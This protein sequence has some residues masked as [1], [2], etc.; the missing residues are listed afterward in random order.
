MTRN[1]IDTQSISDT[2]LVKARKKGADHAVVIIHQQN[3]STLRFA[4]NRATQSMNS[5]K[6]SLTLTV[7]IGTREAS[8]ETDCTSQTCIEA[9]V[10]K[11]VD[12]ARNAPENPEFVEPIPAQT[13][14]ETQTWFESTGSVTS[15]QQGESI[16]LMCDYARSRDVNLFGNLNVHRGE[17]S[18]AN[19]SGLYARQAYSDVRLFTTAR[20]K[21]GGGS[22]CAASGEG[23]WNLLDPLKIAEEAVQTAIRS[24]YPKKVNPGEYVV[25][26]APDA[27]L[28]YLMYILF[29]LDSREAE[30]GQSFFSNRETGGVRTGELIFGKDV[31]L[32]SLFDHS[33]LPTLPFGMTFGSGGSQAGMHFCFGLPM[34]NHIWVEN[35]YLMRLRNSPYWAQKNNRKMVACPFNIVLEGTDTHHEELITGIK[36][37]IYISSFWYTSPTDMTKLEVTGLTRD[38]TFL[39]ENGRIT[40]SLVNFRFND[41]PVRSLNKLLAISRQERVEGEFINGLMPHV[42]IDGFNLTSISEAT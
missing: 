27:L 30:L 41:S 21:S 6:V 34:Q 5:E 35:G 15:A 38:G 23:D 1:K 31:T 24:R 20:S 36:R 40:D 26:L 12:F 17:L 4:L 37:G 8:V 42:L 18:A 13:Y 33:R 16:R 29:A 11:A 28:E 14:P 19:T 7:A 39:I 10:E 3:D 25:V 2:I 22:G 9:L 32:K